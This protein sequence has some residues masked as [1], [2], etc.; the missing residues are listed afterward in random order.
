MSLLNKIFSR[1]K[2]TA[3]HKGIPIGRDKYGK[4]VLWDPEKEHHAFFVGGLKESHKFT[5]VVEN[6]VDN[7]PLEWEAV[8]LYAPAYEMLKVN[9]T[10][11]VAAVKTFKENLVAIEKDIYKR[12]QHNK[13]DSKSKSLIVFIYHAS[14][15][16]LNKQEWESIYP[17]M[18]Y[19]ATE[20]FQKKIQSLM[21]NTRQG[22]VYIVLLDDMFLDYASLVDKYSI[23]FGIETDEN[24]NIYKVNT[25]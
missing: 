8:H 3:D 25:D 9:D 20:F 10:R 2:N 13:T 4:T 19:K 14:M 17:R 12:V 23:D 18:P 21:D 5:N 16:T 6:Y 11:T 24:G 22:N 15:L 7:H 1:S